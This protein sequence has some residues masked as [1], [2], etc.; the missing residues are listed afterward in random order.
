MGTSYQFRCPECRY[1][2]E[3]SGGTDAG[4]RCTT[5]T[6]HCL[7]CQ[8]LYDEVETVV[9]DETPVF[10]PQKVRCPRNARHRWVKWAAPGPCPRCNSV[11]QRGPEVAFWD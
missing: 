6:I 11:L 3:V 7:T 1:E 5:V 9:G 8:E 4:M 10:E 2:A